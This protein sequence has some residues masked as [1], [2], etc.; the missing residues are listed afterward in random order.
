MNKGCLYFARYFFRQL[1]NSCVCLVLLE[2]R[3]GDGLVR[4][5]WERLDTSAW[6]WMFSGWIE[7]LLRRKLILIPPKIKKKELLGYKLREDEF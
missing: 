4:L 5:D 6:M 2:F 1:T 3:V 7:H